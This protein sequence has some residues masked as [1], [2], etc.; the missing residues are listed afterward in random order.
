MVYSYLL[1]GCKNTIR[2]V[3]SHSTVT[4]NYHV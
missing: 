2:T 1:H 3:I 4:T